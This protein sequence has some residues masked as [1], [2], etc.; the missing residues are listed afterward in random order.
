MTLGCA[1]LPGSP[2]PPPLSLLPLHPPLCASVSPGAPEMVALAHSLATSGRCK[3]L[4]ALA[5]DT[6]YP[7]G[8]T[9]GQIYPCRGSP[10]HPLWWGVPGMWGPTWQGCRAETA[11]DHLL[12]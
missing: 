8:G 3:D 2:C 1:P 12:L 11:S 10:S 9:E 6:I 7:T 4:A 5:G